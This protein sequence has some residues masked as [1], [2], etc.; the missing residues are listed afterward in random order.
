MALFIVVHNGAIFLYSCDNKILNVCSEKGPIDY[1]DKR[2]IYHSLISI[3]IT[4]NS[5]YYMNSGV[6]HIKLNR[7]ER[8][9]TWGNGSEFGLLVK[10][11][12]VIYFPGIISK[13][14]VL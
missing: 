11:S 14:S 6:S 5:Q 8:V 12:G 13:C 10:Q 3:L 9:F 2:G 1:S 4:F 7:T